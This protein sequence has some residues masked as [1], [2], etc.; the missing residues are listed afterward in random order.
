M[1]RVLADAIL[2]I[3]AEKN[4]LTSYTGTPPDYSI[5]KPTEKLLEEYQDSR[6][7]FIDLGTTRDLNF[8]KQGFYSREKHLN[9]TTVRWTK[10]TAILLLPFIPSKGKKPVLSFRIIDT[11]PRREWDGAEVSVILNGDRIGQISLH[12]GGDTYRLE[13]PADIKEPGMAA[14][15]IT[16]SGW[17]PSQL[18]GTKDPRLLGIML[19]WMKLTYE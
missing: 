15:S 19:D 18:L 1:A 16:S 5:I 14:I 10:E 12:Q 7:V 3:L 17:Q 8:I 11:G 13:L 6:E 4:R 2:E 9:Q